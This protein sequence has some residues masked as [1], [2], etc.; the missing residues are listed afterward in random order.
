MNTWTDPITGCR[1][2]YDD[3]GS[4]PPVVLIHAFPLCREMWAPQRLALAKTYRVLTP[5]VFGF[6]DSDLPADGWTMDGQADAF[7]AWLTGIGVTR[8]VV[9]GGLSMGGY[10][11]L[12]F[13]RRHPHLVKGLILADTRADAD[14]AETKANRDKTIEFVNQNSAAAQI[15]KMLPAM[16]GRFTR[17]DRPE[18]VAEVRRMGS[19]QTV[20]GVVAAVKAIRDRPDSTASLAAFQFPVLVIVGSDDAITPP[21]LAAAMVEEL[22]DATEEVLDSAGHLSNLESPE[23]FTAAVTRWLA[24]IG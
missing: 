13:A 11:A 9:F 3:A 10:I 19:A 17:D 7:A 15:D 2:A 8:P 6:G 4:G 16:L 5:D 12:A 22:P 23:A 24:A 20:P 14:S 21:A 1:I 18:V